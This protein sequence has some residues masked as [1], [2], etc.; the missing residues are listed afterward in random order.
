MK[1]YL[2]FAL[3]IALTAGGSLLQGATADR[4]RF[5]VFQYC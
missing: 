4:H 2:L 1:N 3:E 5:L